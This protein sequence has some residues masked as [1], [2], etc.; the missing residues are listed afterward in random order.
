MDKDQV[1]E[2]KCKN[3]QCGATLGLIRQNGRGYHQLLIY[4]E[5]IGPDHKGDPPEVMGVLVGLAL[6]IRCSSCENIQPWEPDRE[7]L[8]DML[9]RIDA[10]KNNEIEEAV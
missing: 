6:D 9:A 3:E 10:R 2:W 1:I 7:A 4:R 8:I 5:A